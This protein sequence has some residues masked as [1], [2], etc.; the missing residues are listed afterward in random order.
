MLDALV[1]LYEL[2]LSKKVFQNSLLK[3]PQSYTSRVF[4]TFTS[5]DDLLNLNLISYRR[6]RLRQRFRA[7]NGE[8]ERKWF[9]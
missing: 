7:L 9:N 4:N 6:I 8:N 1:L 5:F 3:Q 2:C